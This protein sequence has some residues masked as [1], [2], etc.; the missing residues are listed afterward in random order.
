[1]LMKW[2]LLVYQN[3]IV[4]K[5]AEGKMPF[6]R[7]HTSLHMTHIIRREEC[8]CM[9]EFSII[10]IMLSAFMWRCEKVFPLFFY[11][12]LSLFKGI[13]FNEDKKSIKF[14]TSSTHQINFQRNPFQRKLFKLKT[15]MNQS[16]RVSELGSLEVFKSFFKFSTVTKQSEETSTVERKRNVTKVGNR[17]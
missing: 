6:I 9:C 17:H 7:F 4:E 1:M 3:D 15:T 16:C 13:Q 11:L 12:R 10:T 5:M 2:K 8:V 14:S